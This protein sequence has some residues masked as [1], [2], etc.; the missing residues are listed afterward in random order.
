M[1]Y[2][3]FLALVFGIIMIT[4]APCVAI[5]GNRWIDFLREVVYPEEQPVWL[6]VAGAASMLLVLLTWYMEI[7]TAVSLSW[8]M[9][10]FVTL[11]IPKFYMLL[12]R[13]SQTRNILISL[14]DRGKAFT[15]SLA[16]LLYIMGLFILGLGIFAF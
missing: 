8:I 13:Y 14:M 5:K 11:A 12:F 3:Q 4:I 6:W 1:L 9:T 2:F 15:L 7:T 16:G 10:L